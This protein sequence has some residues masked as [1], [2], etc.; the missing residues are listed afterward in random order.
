MLS[1]L[2]HNDLHEIYYL[3]INYDEDSFTFET[4]CARVYD[5]LG[6][7]SA[8]EADHLFQSNRVWMKKWKLELRQ[9]SRKQIFCHL[10]KPAAEKQEG[11]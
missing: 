10:G 5:V 6:I 2:W 4:H 1:G 11:S 9:R 3:D 7:K 8:K